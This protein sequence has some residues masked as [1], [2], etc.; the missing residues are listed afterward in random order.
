MQPESN[1]RLNAAQLSYDWS[2]DPALN[3]TP[4]DND[5]DSHHPYLDAKIVGWNMRDKKIASGKMTFVKKENFQFDGDRKKNFV[6]IY[7]QSSFKY[8][9]YVEGH[10]AACRYGFMMLLGSVILKVDSQCVADQMWYFPLLQPY[11]DHVPVK[12][13]MSD[14]KEQIEWCRQHDDECREIAR[15]AQELYYKYVCREGILDYMQM[16]CV[17]IH[18]RRVSQPQWVPAAATSRSAPTASQRM[19]FMG[20]TC[21]AVTYC[22]ICK[23]RKEKEASDAVRMSDAPGKLD[24][25]QLLKERKNKQVEL[26]RQAKKAKLNQ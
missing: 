12:A 7:K 16:V 18:K 22:M 23:R 24:R 20:Q 4:S 17:E 10:C 5:P 1:Q 11:V 13:D 3:G 26:L 8:L 9:L 19:H 25:K 15:R 6:E 14:L 21:D 2:L